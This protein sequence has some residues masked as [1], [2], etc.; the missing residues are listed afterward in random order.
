M[1]NYDRELNELVGQ[2]N[3]KVS[4]P[5]ETPVETHERVEQSQLT[6]ILSAAIQAGASDVLLVP[7]AG[8]AQR[9]ERSGADTARSVAH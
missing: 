2:L 8:I 5:R 9:C 6:A 7:G 3:R 4:A 1:S